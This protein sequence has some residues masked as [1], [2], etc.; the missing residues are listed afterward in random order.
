MTGAIGTPNS[1]HDCDHIIRLA[2]EPTSC[3]FAKNRFATFRRRRERVFQTSQVGEHSKGD[4][5]KGLSYRQ[6]PTLV[7][8]AIKAAISALRACD[9][10]TDIGSDSGR[11]IKRR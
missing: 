2:D 4:G 6:S 5:R 8:I 1:R 11:D 3:W 9:T 7:A 10:S